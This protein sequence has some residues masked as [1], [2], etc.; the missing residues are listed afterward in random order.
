M[1][2]R[3][4]LLV[5]AFT[6][7]SLSADAAPAQGVIHIDSV[8]APT[9]VAGLLG[10]S[11]QRAASVYLPPGYSVSRVR[12]YP[13]IYLLHG[14]GATHR[15]FIR[16]AYQNLNIRL[17]MDSLI[18]TGAIREMIVV[19]PDANSPLGGS[20]YSNSPV[21]GNW[22]DFIVRDLVRFVDRKYR[23]IRDRHGRGI[24][25]HSMGG[26][27]ALHLG[28]RHPDKFSAIYALS[29]CCLSYDLDD[30][31][32]RAKPWRAAILADT[33]EEYSLAGFHA[34]LLTSLGAVL[35]PDATRPPWFVRY[36]FAMT[37][38]SLVRDPL[39]VAKWRRGPLALA[40]EYA[41][42][43]MRS[44][45]AVDAGDRDGLTDI[46]INARKFHVTLDS[47]GVPHTFEIYP[48]THGD[49]FRERLEQKA[50][51]FFSAA[52]REP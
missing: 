10:G 35:S 47:L 32:I 38:D 9:L 29:P 40:P 36:P 31:I 51:P 27:G 49:R 19:T 3:R 11:A 43:L 41:G 46:P 12:R 16:G 39:A 22:E 28:M 17:S 18:R 1:K 34:N 5:A 33:R 37:A 6:A 14:Y 13:V 44:R 48:G 52:L 8:P 24:A 15:A 45:I 42:N 21:T 20:F 23:T 4:L 2:M 50:L 7:G 30:P 26:Y 25:G